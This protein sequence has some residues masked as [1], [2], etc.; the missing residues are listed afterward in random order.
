LLDQWAYLNKVELD[1]SRPGRPTDNVYIEAFN[2]RLRQ[3]CLNALWFLA[4]T[5]ARTG[6]YLFLPAKGSMHRGPAK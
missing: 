6:N 2:S 4:M 1:C 3:E 5:D